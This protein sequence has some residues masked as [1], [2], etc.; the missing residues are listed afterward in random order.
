MGWSMVDRRVRKRRSYRWMVADQALPRL[1]WPQ[2]RRQRLFGGREWFVPYLHVG[3]VAADEDGRRQG[4]GPRTADSGPGVVDAEHVPRGTGRV[5]DQRDAL[6]KY[7]G[8]PTA[9][10]HRQERA[11]VARVPCLPSLPSFKLAEGGKRRVGLPGGQQPCPDLVGGPYGQD[12]EGLLTGDARHALR[13]EERDVLNGKHPSAAVVDVLDPPFGPISILH[14]DEGVRPRPRP[15]SQMHDLAP[16]SR[17][18][19]EVG[20][21]PGQRVGAEI[22]QSGA[23]VAAGEGQ[24]AAVR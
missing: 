12:N 11:V 15:R 3:P 1:Q 23:A 20:V 2:A 21:Q 18:V 8:E 6:V 24:L 14:D 17:E 10:V 4:G 5:G 22:D 19:D 9:G 7:G 13:V 16:A